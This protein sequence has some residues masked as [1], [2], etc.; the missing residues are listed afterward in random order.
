MFKL[1]R[2]PH[3]LYPEHLSEEK[4]LYVNKKVAYTVQ[5]HYN[6]HY[7]EF[8]KWINDGDDEFYVLLNW[9]LIPLDKESRKYR[10]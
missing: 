8:R 1:I 2:K 4:M 3:Q 10:R 5:E 9:K 7:I 6:P